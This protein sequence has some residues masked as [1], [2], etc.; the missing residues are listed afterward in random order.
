MWKLLLLGLLVLLHT[1]IFLISMCNYEAKSSLF[2]IKTAGL[3]HVPIKSYSKNTHPP[4]ILKWILISLIQN[5]LMLFR[6][7]V[8]HFFLLHALSI[9]SSRAYYSLKLFQL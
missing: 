9:C 4:F 6:S 1:R 8:L 3:Y 2:M 7:Q 5:G